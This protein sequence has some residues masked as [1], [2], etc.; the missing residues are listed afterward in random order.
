MK[1]SNL[2]QSYALSKGLFLGA[3][4]LS[5][6][7]TTYEPLDLPLASGMTVGDL[8]RSQLIT[9]DDSAVVLLYD[10]EAC[11]V[12]AT[13]LSQWLEYGRTNPGRVFLI[14]GRQPKS[15]ESRQLALL[16]LRPDG[17][18]SPGKGASGP[19]LELLVVRGR[20]VQTWAVRSGSESPLLDLL[21]R[22]SRRPATRTRTD[23]M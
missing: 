16:H 9:N 19:P 13:V 8:V 2:R 14:L 1:R 10:P 21:V 18:V 12:C 11:F 6:R 22:Q 23:Q 20:V 15:S 3:L 4:L 7:N 5:C 17:I